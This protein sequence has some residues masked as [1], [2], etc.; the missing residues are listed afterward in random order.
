MW[1]ITIPMQHMHCLNPSKLSSSIQGIAP[2][3]TSPG[4]IREELLQ[5]R[6]LK[7]RHSSFSTASQLPLYHTNY[8]LPI[9]KW[10]HQSEAPVGAAPPTRSQLRLQR[11][12]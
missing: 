1:L 8:Q 5:D 12:T 2:F 11:Q 3:N 7:K 10:P 6:L 4:A 9:T